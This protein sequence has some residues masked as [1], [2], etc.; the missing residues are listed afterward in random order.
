MSDE[1][2]GYDAFQRRK[3][4]QGGCFAQFCSKLA[5]HLLIEV[6]GNFLDDDSSNSETEDADARGA[7]LVQKGDG[8]VE[9]AYKKRE[10]YFKDRDLIK[11]RM[12][13]PHTHVA[14]RGEKP[15]SCVWCCRRKHDARSMQKHISRHG[16]ATKFYCPVCMVSLCNVKRFDGQSCHDLFHSSTQL[17]DYCVAAMDS[18]VH[19]QPH[20]NRPPPPRRG[21]AVAAAAAPASDGSSSEGA[22]VDGSSSEGAAL[23]AAGA[24]ASDGSTS[25]GDEAVEAEGGEQQE[26]SATEL[27]DTPPPRNVTRVSTRSSTKRIRVQRTRNRRPSRRMLDVLDDAASSSEED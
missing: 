13:R 16:R 6:P 15:R 27:E 8:T 5:S 11:R 22:E 9:V 4:V 17:V 20:S 1:C 23:A 21:A 19:V 14:A 24:P 10:K 26:A 3:R 25:E 18:E 7:L 12:E 2:K